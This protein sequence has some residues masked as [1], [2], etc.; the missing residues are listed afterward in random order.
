MHLPAY[1]AGKASAEA[2]QNTGFPVVSQGAGY[3]SI[4]NLLV[5]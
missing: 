1:M 5:L 2:N 4:L 3:F